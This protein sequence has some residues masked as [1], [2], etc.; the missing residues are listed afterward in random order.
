[1]GPDG[2]KGTAGRLLH[3]GWQCRGCRLQL[4]AQGLL[5][6]AGP[7]SQQWVLFLLSYLNAGPATP[8]RPLHIW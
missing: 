1:M 5:G 3:R 2:Q 6:A 8:K 7:G 4:S